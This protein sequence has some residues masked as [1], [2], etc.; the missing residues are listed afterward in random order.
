MSFERHDRC[1]FR[2]MFPRFFLLFIAS[3]GIL[4]CAQDAGWC[5]PNEAQLPTGSYSVTSATV[6]GLYEAEV[7]V[8]ASELSITYAGVDG[9]T[10]TVVYEVSPR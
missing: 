3:T 6:E 9:E 2:K 10:V 8:T 5:W 1:Y 7:T 4:G